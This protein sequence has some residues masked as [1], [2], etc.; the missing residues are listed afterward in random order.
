MFGGNV[1]YVDTNGKLLL[2]SAGEN[3]TAAALNAQIVNEAKHLPN[4]K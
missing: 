1:K 3:D 4:Y 2:F